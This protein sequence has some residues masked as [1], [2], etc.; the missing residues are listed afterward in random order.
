VT[1]PSRP[2]AHDIY[3]RVRQDAEDELERPNSSLAFS[4]LFAGFTIGA[5]PLAVALTLAALG[6]DDSAR[7]VADLV[8]PIGFIAV[9]LGR[10]QL[11]T[12]N[13]LYPVVLSFR[14]RSALRGT[15]RLWGMVFAGNLVGSLGFALLAV[16]SG[17]IDGAAVDSLTS[18]GADSAGTPFSEV[19][20]SAVVAGWLLALIAWLVEATESAIAQVSVVWFLAFLVGLGTFDHCVATTVEVAGALF[21][22]DIGIGDS[23]GWL[24]TATLGNVAGGV[25]I[26]S[27]LN[28]GQ[29]R[30]ES[31]A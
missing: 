5:T 22:G 13:T 29:V 20:W 23:L 2:S 18:F 19:F 6:T 31:G 9:I 17:A 12:E 16:E 1:E 8:F 3:D 10:S 7:F 14:Q 11:F 15:A 30:A 24:A 25:L 26:V 4:A 28:Y 21:H 27:L